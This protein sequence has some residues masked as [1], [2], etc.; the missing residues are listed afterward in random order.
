[1]EERKQSYRSELYL[2]LYRACAARTA[3]LHGALRER[4]TGNL[5]SQPDAGKRAPTDG[6]N[7]GD[8]RQR[9]SRA[10]DANRRRL[11][12]APHQRLH[13]RGGVDR[14][15]RRRARQAA[16]DARRRYGTRL[17]PP[18]RLPLSQ[19][20]AR[21]FGQTRRMAEPF[22]HL[23]TGHDVRAGSKYSLQRVPGDVYD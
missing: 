22:R 20:G 23:W 12:P 2:P 4:K 10:P 3:E 14:K 19:G 21:Q 7:A 6:Q 1:D 5:G 8:E 17:L 11:R 16:M 13:G 15:S 9:Y 18:R